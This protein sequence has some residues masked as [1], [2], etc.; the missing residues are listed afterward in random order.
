MK[1][2]VVV[3]HESY[4]GFGRPEAAFKTQELAENYIAKECIIPWN[5]HSDYRI[6]E[7]DFEGE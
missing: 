2:Y 5:L 6:I 7:L 4:E 1:V 3:T